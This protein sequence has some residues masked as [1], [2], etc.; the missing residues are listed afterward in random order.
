MSEPLRLSFE[1]QCSIS[2]AFDVWTSG[3]GRWWPRDHTMSGE[4]EL[5]V[6]L[7][8]GVGGRIFERTSSGTEHDWGEVTLWEPPSRLSYRWHLGSE[9]ESA[10]E[11]DIQFSERGAGVTEVAIEHDGWD[12]LGD[13]ASTMRTRNQ[14]GWNSLVPHYRSAVST[15]EH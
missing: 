14:T 3:I 1:V 7:E 13:R 10:T 4:S 6:V 2:H 12:R 9:P 15:G 5:S 8:P 11:V